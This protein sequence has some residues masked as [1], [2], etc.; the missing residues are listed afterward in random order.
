MK[1]ET[2]VNRYF[3][4]YDL[5]RLES[6]TQNLLDYHVIIDLIPSLARLYFMSMLDGETAETSVKLSPVQASILLGVGLQKMQ[7]TDLETILD[8]P[9]S[10]ILALFGKTVKKCTNFL[11]GLV[12]KGVSI[13]VEDSA[14]Q[15]PSI[16]DEK[17]DIENEEEW[18][19]VKQGLD[20]DLN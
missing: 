7:V 9:S 1:T 16:S 10:Q 20:A 2:D 5:K 6:Y 11:K 14:K 17:R 18:D 15:H 13:E 3:S 12:E 4:V 19:P 8:L